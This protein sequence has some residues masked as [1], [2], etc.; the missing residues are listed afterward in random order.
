MTRIPE[1]VVFGLM[2]LVRFPPRGTCVMG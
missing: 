2:Q 1:I